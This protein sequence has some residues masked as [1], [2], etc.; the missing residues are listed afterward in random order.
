MAEEKKQDFWV[1]PELDAS[2][3]EVEPGPGGG[4]M[5]AP[6]E[7]PDFWVPEGYTAEQVEA[8][9]A[10]PMFEEP[11]LGSLVEGG[12]LM[13]GGDEAMAALAYA[14][15]RA[16][17][18]DHEE[19]S[20]E[21]ARQLKAEREQRK[22][23]SEANP[24]GSA[25]LEIAGGALM[26]IG[27][28]GQSKKLVDLAKASPKLAASI[29]G[30]A[31][32][33]TTGFLEGEGGFGERAKSAGIGGGMGAV[34][35]PA[36]EL[37]GDVV[38]P[39][40]KYLSRLMG[41]D[42]GDRYADR[43]V[44]QALEKQGL[45]VDQVEPY[46]RDMSKRGVTISDVDELFRKI[47]QEVTSKPGEARRTATQFLEKRGAERGER[48]A[49]DMRE[50]IS[51]QDFTTA[52][53][54]TIANRQAASQPLYDAAMD[55]KPNISKDFNNLL[56]KSPTMRQVFDRAR[57]QY[58]DKYLEDL[59]ELYREVKPGIW[60]LD[61]APDT[62]TLHA[63]KMALDDIISENKNFDAFGNYKGLTAKGRQ[64]Q[65][66]KNKLLEQMDTNILD[67]NRNPVY[68]QAREAF[69]GE[70]ALLDAMQTGRNTYL[71]SP[72]ELAATLNKLD[73]SERDAFRIGVAKAIED[74]MGQSVEDRVMIRRILG[75]KNQSK[76][77]KQLE[78]VF[79]NANDFNEFRRRLLGESQM[80]VTEKRLPSELRESGIVSKESP[81]FFPMTKQHYIPQFMLRSFEPSETERSAILKRIMTPGEEG[82]NLLRIAEDKA[83][84]G[85]LSRLWES[86][87]PGRQAMRAPALQSILQMRTPGDEEE[88]N[89]FA[90]PDNL[91]YGP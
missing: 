80:A 81:V 1:P 12:M 34:L 42:S 53:N 21:A 25:A 36:A 69:A 33:A 48:I 73:P 2:E 83:K 71:S 72:E 70:S 79:D 5:L 77:R 14:K 45:T 78:T 46:L 13:G 87:R 23:F 66:L 27:I 24:F 4:V 16:S 62:R 88:A 22:A 7:K 57:T 56:T 30:G 19:A 84:Q 49:E 9:K 3:V 52:R 68:K 86:S 18:M 37:V 60:Q 74:K 11:W 8:K 26:P 38:K 51:A 15:A 29:L 65:D 44:A 43:V 40:A 82:V 50:L 35:G 55:I 61:T 6:A 28:L 32:G 76:Q 64:Y 63:M 20:L 90:I 31:G 85:P 17:G 58:Q 39:T 47:A 10:T 75:D 41:F 54:A 67:A 89:P 59:P 91:L